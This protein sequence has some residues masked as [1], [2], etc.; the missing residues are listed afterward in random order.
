MG[1]ESNQD[2]IKTVAENPEGKYDRYK[3]KYPQIFSLWDKIQQQI[4]EGTFKTRDT[5]LNADNNVLTYDRLKQ[6]YND[7]VPDSADAVK[8]LVK[9][10]DY[11]YD[12]DNNFNNFLVVPEYEKVYF[13]NYN[14]GDFV[15]MRFSPILRKIPSLSG[16]DMIN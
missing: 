15:P 7:T 12:A 3:V 2:F 8:T 4:R 14:G 6:F 13:K 11:I 16:I 5:Y 9:S 1:A 10:Y